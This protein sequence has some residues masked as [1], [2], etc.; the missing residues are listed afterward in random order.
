VV[1]V[2]WQD[3]LCRTPYWASIV[4]DRGHPLYG[5][6]RARLGRLYSDRELVSAWMTGRRSTLEVVQ[7]LDVEGGPRYTPEYLCR[8]LERDCRLMRVNVE[9]LRALRTARER[10]FVVIATDNVDAFATTYRRLTA[11]RG[12]IPRPLPDSVPADSLAAWATGCDD[13]V[14]SSDVG[15]LKSDPAA[16]F[17]A[18]LRACGLGFAD[19]LLIDD[20]SDN[21]TAFR[22]A[23]GSA[24][25]WTMH[26]DGITGLVTE[27]ERWLAA[28]D[29]RAIVRA[30]V[31]S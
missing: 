12:A 28:A 11:R 6:L 15:A 25:R 27:L 31:K 1:F 3:V 9:L 19:A 20:R 17:S 2:D 7:S 29:A 10:A 24:V 23:G 30:V 18:Y 16:F 22:A 13:L 21:C 26:S 14:C 8:Q 4:S 5:P